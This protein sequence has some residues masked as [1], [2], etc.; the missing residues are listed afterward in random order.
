MVQWW[1]RQFQWQPSG[2]IPRLTLTVRHSTLEDLPNTVTITT[3]AA[4]AANNNVCLSLCKQNTG[5]TIQ[6]VIISALCV[7]VCFTVKTVPVSTTTRLLQ[8]HQLPNCFSVWK[9]NAAKPHTCAA[10]LSALSPDPQL[11][12]SIEKRVQLDYNVS[13]NQLPVDVLSVWKLPHSLLF[14]EATNRQQQTTTAA[15]D[16]FDLRRQSAFAFSFRYTER[17]TTDGK[18]STVTAH[19]A[20]SCSLSLQSLLV[21]L[22][23]PP[24]SQTVSLPLHLWLCLY[25]PINVHLRSCH[26]QDHT[27]VMRTN[28]AATATAANTVLVDFCK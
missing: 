13:I 11:G 6:T 28:A 3:I 16:S 12:Q 21:S 20:V 7:H 9:N 4:A 17:Q 8:Q 18:V 10:V 15:A 24:P 5:N 23:P 1:R 25:W 22:P 26:R 19:L 14:L 27:G 2:W